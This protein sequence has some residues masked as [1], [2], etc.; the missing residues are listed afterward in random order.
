MIL[1]LITDSLGKKAITSALAMC[2]YMRSEDVRVQTR[3]KLRVASISVRGNSMMNSVV[4][5]P[6]GG[7]RDTI[8]PGCERHTASQY[9]TAVH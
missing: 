1:L 4:F 2:N 6:R 7:N 8:L 5:K 3:M 9:D